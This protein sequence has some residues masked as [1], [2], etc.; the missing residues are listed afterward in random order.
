[1][2]I[3][4]VSVSGNRQARDG[5]LHVVAERVGRAKVG[6]RRKDPGAQPRE[7]SRLPG[8]ARNQVNGVDDPLLPDPIDAADALLEPH[9]VPRQLE[10]HD[11]AASAMEVQPLGRGVGG[12][13]DAA[14]QALERVEHGRTL[15]AP[16]PAMQDHQG[17]A[18]RGISRQPLAQMHQRVAIL[19]EDDR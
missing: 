17:G 4:I 10:V 9:R 7:D 11:E 15:L 1:M 13:Q 12:E 18:E 5:S 6:L 3:V 14:R 8:A 2:F 19:G 16:E